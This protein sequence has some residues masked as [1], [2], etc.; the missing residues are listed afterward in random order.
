MRGL[1]RD[2]GGLDSALV[3]LASAANSV[4]AM[5]PSGIYATSTAAQAATAAAAAYEQQANALFAE[6]KAGS[7]S[8]EQAADSLAALNAQAQQS[9]DAF[10]RGAQVIAANATAEQRYSQTTSELNSLLA[11]GAIDQGTFQRAMDAAKSS[12]DDATGATAAQSQAAQQLAQTMERGAAV[13]RSVAT[14]EERHAS[15]IAE[16]QSLLR[17]GAISQQTYTRAIDKANVELR[18]SQTAARAAATGIASVSASVGS[19]RSRL[20]ALVAIQGAQLF[21][22]I[23]SSATQAIR[24]LVGMGAAAAGVIDNTNKLANRLGFTYGEMAGVANAGALVDVSLETIAGAT[25]KAEINF[26]KAASGSQ[27]ATAAFESIGLAVDNLNG[28]TAAERFQAIAQAI[29]Q[30][31]TEA[32]RAAAA[33]RIFGRSGVELLPMFQEG[34][35]GIQAATAEAERFG[36]TLNSAQTNNVDRMGDAFDRAKQA[37]A[38]VIQQ[39]VAYLAPAV[40]N[41]TTAFSNLIGSIGGATIG[42]TIGQ[43]ILQGARFL[44]QIGDWL[45]ASLSSV[46]QY[47]SQVGGQ[48]SAVWEVAS[49]VASFLAGVGDIF[50]AVFQVGILGMSAI[51]EGLLTAAKAIGD[52]AGFDTTAIDDARATVQGFNQG[53]VDDIMENIKSAGKNFNDAFNGAGADEAGK[54]IAGPLTTAVD[55]AIAAAQQ[56][57]NQVDTATRKKIEVDGKEAAADIKAATRGELKGLDVRSAEGMKELNRLMREGSGDNLQREANDLLRG[58]KQNTEDMGGT[59]EVADLAPAAGV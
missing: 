2:A 25:Q 55:A 7:I 20:T 47:V 17:S 42:Q 45:V 8:A 3:K 6:L 41:V 43:G 21:G 12:L 4:Q 38:G 53:M 54:A 29:S 22:S 19:L 39:V 13:A 58:I 31:P 57:A 56:A 48:W 35:A 49:R 15:S 26:A 1:R 37:V 14:A 36:L 27:A 34:A 28:M 52:V 51:A 40:E 50:Q 59:D 9:A 46:W 10:S 5:D 24:S 32:E 44:A 30:L 11:A 23:T 16:L 18:Q 33:V